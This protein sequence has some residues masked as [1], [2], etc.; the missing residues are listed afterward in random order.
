M[1]SVLYCVSI[2]L[3]PCYEF[4]EPRGKYNVGYKE[5]KINTEYKTTDCSVFYP[6]DE[7][8]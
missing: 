6:T 7:A 4:P 1:F 5:L 3:T 8:Y 2:Y